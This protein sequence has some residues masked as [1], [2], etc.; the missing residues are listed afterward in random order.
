MPHRCHGLWVSK[1]KIYR[2]PIPSKTRVGAHVHECCAPA[3]GRRRVS[4]HCRR[5][6]PRTES[7]CTQPRAPATA[8]KLP[9][10]AAEGSQAAWWR[11]WPGRAGPGRARA[12]PVRVGSVRLYV[13]APLRVPALLRADVSVFS[14]GVL[15][16]GML[17]EICMLLVETRKE[18]Q[19]AK[20]GRA[21]MNFII[22]GH[23]FL[24]LTFL[25]VLIFLGVIF[26]FEP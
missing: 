24:L 3:G 22:S 11:S 25:V 16:T 18:R 19:R 6:E 12:G 14:V 2:K 26:C 15:P 8:A 21:L 4:C 20:Y 5:G 1:Y 9:A 23:F 7:P 17:D 10:T 13:P